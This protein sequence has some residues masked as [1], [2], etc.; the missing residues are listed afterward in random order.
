MLSTS[1]LQ[2]PSMVKCRNISDHFIRT[3]WPVQIIHNLDCQMNLLIFEEDIHGNQWSNA[4]T[5]VNTTAQSRIFFMI[6]IAAIGGRSGG[7]TNADA[8]E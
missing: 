3:E 4:A 5:D 1:R 2:L 7:S 8:K 6:Q